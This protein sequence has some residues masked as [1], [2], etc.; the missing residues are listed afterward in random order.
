V[1]GFDFVLVKW[2][3][4]AA[5]AAIGARL[6]LLS[7]G[8]ITAALAATGRH[9]AADWHDYHLAAFT[10]AARTNSVLARLTIRDRAAICF[11]K[12]QAVEK[13]EIVARHYP[14]PIIE[15]IP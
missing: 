13:A 6:Y 12:V 10:S 9:T 8:R 11:H 15:A 4:F 3:L 14:P 2:R 1:R 7:R 5:S